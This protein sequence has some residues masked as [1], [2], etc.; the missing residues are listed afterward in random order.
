MI[1]IVI[2]T[3]GLCNRSAPAAVLLLMRRPAILLS[4]AAFV[5]QGKLLSSADGECRALPTDLN[6]P[7]LRTRK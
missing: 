6:R 1:M 2:L 3:R 5:S 7:Y 4:G